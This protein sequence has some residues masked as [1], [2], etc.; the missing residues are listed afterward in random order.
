MTW[1][2]R[3]DEGLPGHDWGRRF[4]PSRPPHATLLEVAH[5]L[6]QAQVANE[7]LM[8]CRQRPSILDDRQAT[9]RASASWNL[10]KAPSRRS[11][12]TRDTWD[13]KTRRNRT[14][15]VQMMIRS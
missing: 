9:E 7:P 4:V 14:K 5:L 13:F 10:I 1:Y 3:D 8:L 6:S 15:Y 12:H 11:I 2:Q